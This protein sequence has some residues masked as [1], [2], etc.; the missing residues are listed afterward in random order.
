MRC[1]EPENRAFSKIPMPRTFRSIQLIRHYIHICNI[2][3]ETGIYCPKITMK[4]KFNF[5][6]STPPCKNPQPNSIFVHNISIS[7][8]HFSFFL[9]TY[10]NCLPAHLLPPQSSIRHHCCYLHPRHYYLMKIPKQWK[11]DSRPHSINLLH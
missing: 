6:S 3:F 1:L 8:S 7:L 2:C 11:K 10:S 9:S 4:Y 5:I